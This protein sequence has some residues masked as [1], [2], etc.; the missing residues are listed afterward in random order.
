[1]TASVALV[2]RSSAAWA[3]SGSLAKPALTSR[4]R[5]MTSLHSPSPAHAPD[6]P[7]KREPGL[8]VAD[9]TTG[10][11]RLKAAVHVVPQSS[12]AGTLVTVPSP[13]PPRVTA[14]SIWR[15]VFVTTHTTSAPEA[16][17]TDSDALLLTDATTEP[18]PLPSRQTI[19]VV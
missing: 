2:M 11:P 5:S 9:R 19:P 13:V 8:G 16:T 17:G 14:T 1:M 6:H 3:L 18:A 4:G 12:A 10:S 15:R 7:V